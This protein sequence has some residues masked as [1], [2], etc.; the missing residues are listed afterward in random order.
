MAMLAY[1]LVIHFLYIFFNL[2]KFPSV[3]TELEWTHT[4]T[5]HILANLS[6]LKRESKH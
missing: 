4:Q 6:D 2:M 3:L 5:D 1:I